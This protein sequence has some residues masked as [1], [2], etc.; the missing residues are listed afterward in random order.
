MIDDETA[1]SGATNVAGIPAGKG[2]LLSAFMPTALGG[3]N[4]LKLIDNSGTVSGS[5]VRQE[6]PDA[7]IATSTSF[8]R[9]VK[10]TVPQVNTDYIPPGSGVS[11]RILIEI[12]KP[13]GTTEDVTQTILSM[14]VTEGEPNGIVYLQRPLWAAYVQ[15]KP[16]PVGR[17]I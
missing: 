14:G 17:N 1:G 2:V 13:D 4:V 9:T 10:A 7:S 12:V 11:G 15:G 16:R 5:A 3:G 8:V 6:N